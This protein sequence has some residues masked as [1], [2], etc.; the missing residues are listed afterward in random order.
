MGK[1]SFTRRTLQAEITAYFNAI[2]H[3]VPVFDYLPGEKVTTSGKPVML[4]Q[5]ALDVNGAPMQILEYCRTPSVA[6][7]CLYL[8]IDR[9]TLAQFAA[10]ETLRPA[11]EYARLRIED[12]YVEELVGHASSGAKFALAN[13]CGWSGW[14]EKQ[15]IEL[16]SDTRKELSNLSLSEKLQLIARAADTAGAHHVDAD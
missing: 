8:G 3:M 1:K 9:Q 11:V 13:D 15:E 2:S 10:D 7:L 6:G 14:Q 4:A 5:Q 12:Y 16:G